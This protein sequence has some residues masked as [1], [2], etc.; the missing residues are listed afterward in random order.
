[1]KTTLTEIDPSS[2]RDYLTLKGW[3]EKEPHQGDLMVF[4]GPSDDDHVPIIQ[5]IP[6]SRQAAD[7]ALRA[8]E[9]VDALSVI[10]DRRVDLV[11][12][13]IA[14]RQGTLATR[15]GRRLW[16]E[17]A[18]YFTRRPT[19]GDAVAASLFVG[20]AISLYQANVGLR[21]ARTEDLALKAE[22]AVK[23]ANAERRKAEIAEK[24]TEAERRKAEIAEKLTEDVRQ[25]VDF[26]VRIA[27]TGY[28]NEV[29]PQWVRYEPRADRVEVMEEL[30]G[31][32]KEPEIAIRE[33]LARKEWDGSSP[34]TIA[35]LKEYLMI[36]VD[37]AGHSI[38]VPIAQDEQADIATRK[39]AVE[40]LALLPER[41]SV[42]ALA[43]IVAGE[44]NARDLR[45]LAAELLPRWGQGAK[46]A[47]LPL[48]RMENDKDETLAHVAARVIEQILRNSPKSLPSAP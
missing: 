32:I 12:R 3:M 15:L 38:L 20:I 40:S 41:A 34:G 42:E 19:I 1:M 48:R 24:L 13:D 11:V 21:A 18:D 2:F 39:H 22:I 28:D 27:D 25:V 14:A 47:L 5:V 7:F 17:V 4:E 23:L 6:R 26:A 44:K 37:N 29:N 33:L 8:R 10:E 31:A 35:T 45:K 46:A 30:L 9:L 43:R 16:E 36:L